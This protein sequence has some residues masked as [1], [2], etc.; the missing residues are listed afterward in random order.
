MSPTVPSM[1]MNVLLMRLDGDPRLAGLAHTSGSLLTHLSS[2]I[3]VRSH[4]RVVVRATPRR[5]VLGGSLLSALP[6]EA[7]VRQGGYTLRITLLDDELSAV[8]RQAASW[9]TDPLAADAHA[10]IIDAIITAMLSQADKLTG[11]IAQVATRGQTAMSL[12]GPR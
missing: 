6:S 8:T 12:D 11:W 3:A 4:Q 9:E 5:A 1:T 7:A 2:S 10:Y